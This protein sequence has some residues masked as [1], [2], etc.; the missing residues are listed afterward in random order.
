VA[1]LLDIL[2]IT[3]Q[4]LARVLKQ[5]VDEGFISQRAGS[6]DRRERLLKVTQKGA[7]LCEKLTAL[8]VKRLEGALAKAGLGSSEATRKF[9]FAMIADDERPYVKSLIGDGAPRLS[10]EGETSDGA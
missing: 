10:L 9:L 7:K 6:V 2:K 5:L 8:Q 1:E 4:S 3:K